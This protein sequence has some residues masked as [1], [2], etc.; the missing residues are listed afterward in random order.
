[1]VYETLNLVLRKTSKYNEPGQNSLSSDHPPFSPSHISFLD[2]PKQIITTVAL[3]RKK[4]V[5]PFI[6]LGAKITDISWALLC[7]RIDGRFCSMLSQFF[8]VAGTLGILGL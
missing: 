7:L 4:G 6:I 5:C 1:M 3:K 8:D 2:L